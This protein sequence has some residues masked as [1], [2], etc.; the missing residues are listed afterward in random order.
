[1]GWSARSPAGGAIELMSDSRVAVIEQAIKAIALARLARGQSVAEV[2]AALTDAGLDEMSAGSTPRESVAAVRQS[3]RKAMLA[4]L[5]R[6]VQLGRGR[7]GPMLVAHRFAADP[8]DP[9]E[10]ASLARKLRRWRCK[11]LRTVSDSSPSNQA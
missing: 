8:R 7:A 6:L 4:E 1:M 10:V 5:E 3:Q 9:V 2:V 11:D